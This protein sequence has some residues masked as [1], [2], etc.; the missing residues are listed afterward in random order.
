MPDPYLNLAV[1]SY[2]HGNC[3]QGNSSNGTK[4]T[5][6]K[7]KA[8]IPSG[9]TPYIFCRAYGP[10]RSTAILCPGTYIWIGDALDLSRR[11]SCRPRRHTV[12][13]VCR[14]CGDDL[15]R[16]V[17]IVLTTPAALR[18]PRHITSGKLDV[19]LHGA[20]VGSAIRD[21]RRTALDL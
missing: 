19:H 14:P 18:T 2:T 15:D 5:G 20:D 7:E 17:T 16:G 6:N 11:D 4:I 12:P 3:D 21:R 1:P 13:D 10:G 8:Y 9:S